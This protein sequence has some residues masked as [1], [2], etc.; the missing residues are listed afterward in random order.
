MSFGALSGPAIEAINRGAHLA[1]CLH[2]T[3]EG[4]ASP[5]HRHGGELIW[6]IGT[7][8]FGCRDERGN[9]SL[10]KLLEAVDRDP[11]R[12]IEIKLS[13]GAKP[14]V[15]GMLP[16][17]KVTAEIAATR[18]IP[19][20]R[21]CASPSVHREFSNADELLDFVESIASETGLPVGI[22]SAIG[23]IRFWRDLARLM[24]ATDRGVDFITVDGGEGGTG[25]APL[26][27]TDHVGLPFKIG[28]TRV[29]REFVEAGI[30]D[31][32]VFVGSGKLGFPETALLAMSLG[33]DLIAVAREAM[34]SIGCIQ[35]Q[36]CHTGHCP[37]GIATQNKWLMHG[38]DPTLKSARLANYVV[39]LRR[40]LL[41]L[42]RSCGHPHPALVPADCLEIL[43]G[44]HH[45]RTAAD[46]F[47]YLDGWGL[48]NAEEQ[49]Q[50]RYLMSLAPAE[51]NS[52]LTSTENMTV[53]G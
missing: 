23:E 37:A 53:A 15:G 7:S 2:N 14:G 49:E 50:I 3:G 29:Y 45:G 41:R 18:G 39:T 26:V 42:A 31:Q 40:E 8:Y 27:F 34:M 28:F 52:I 46:L 48:P 19:V 17:A 1:D 21:D 5:Y 16:G 51:R 20:G 30:H 4:A 35:A 24:A 12:A 13:Q 25:A 43:D 36:K 32:V 6:Q 10:P 33:C 38:L 47:S 9:F 11:V 22:K 44:Q